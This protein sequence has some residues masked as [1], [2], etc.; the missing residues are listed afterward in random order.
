M[1]HLELLVRDPA[2]FLRHEF[3]D[4]LQQW[5]NRDAGCLG[6]AERQPFGATILGYSATRVQ[7]QTGI[8][9]A[10]DIDNGLS[11]EKQQCDHQSEDKHAGN[12]HVQ[13]QDGFHEFASRCV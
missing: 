10:F 13:A 8:N 4:H 3:F 7:L 1:N 2:L 12:N 5:R 6:L 11:R 9:F